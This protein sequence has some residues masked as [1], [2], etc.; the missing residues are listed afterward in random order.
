MDPLL[1][2][3]SEKPLADGEPDLAREQLLQ[4]IAKN[5]DDKVALSNLGVIACKQNHLG[6]AA[7]YFAKC[8]GV[9]PF[10]LDGVL[11]FCD[12]LK[13]TVRL[14]RVNNGVVKSTF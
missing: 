6:Q 4:A 13:T 11:N 14:R 12:L 5:P 10:Y 1:S 2:K 9:D 8:I 7:Q 3:D